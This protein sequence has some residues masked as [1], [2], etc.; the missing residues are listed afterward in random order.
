MVLG[1]AVLRKDEADAA[2][3][4]DFILLQVKNT[5]SRARAGQRQVLCLRRVRVPGT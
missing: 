1:W 5:S 4:R 3:K 2:S